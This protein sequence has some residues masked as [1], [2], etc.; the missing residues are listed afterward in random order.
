M[1]H[2]TGH[3]LH[4]VTGN[5]LSA[6]EFHERLQ[7]KEGEISSNMFSHLSAGQQ[8]SYLHWL[9][10]NYRVVQNRYTYL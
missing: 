6:K 9:P 1:C 8:L 4:S 2:S 10:V 7:N 5:K 3:M